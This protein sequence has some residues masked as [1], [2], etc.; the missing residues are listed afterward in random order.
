MIPSEENNI[1]PDGVMM[2]KKYIVRLSDEERKK[3][4][5]L[6]SE[7]K[8]AAYKIRHANILLKAEADGPAWK[9]EQIASCFSIRVDT[10]IAVRQR[11]AERGLEA[12][13]NRKKQDY[14]SRKPIL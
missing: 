10:V 13:I 5:D 9:D 2:N 14:P 11:F 3:L 7:G 12:A 8:A 4:N 1:L 6:T